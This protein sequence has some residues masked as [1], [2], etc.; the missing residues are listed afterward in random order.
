MFSTST[1]KLENMFSIS[2]S[3]DSLNLP[4]LVE[5]ELKKIVKVL[6]ISFVSHL[7]VLKVLKANNQETTKQEVLISV[8]FYL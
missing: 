7:S 2:V 8:F 4:G 5:N 1:F 3:T 6:N